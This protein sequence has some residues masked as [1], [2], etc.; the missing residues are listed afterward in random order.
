MFSRWGYNHYK[1][2][3]DVPGLHHRVKKAA[4]QFKKNKHEMTL[5]ITTKHKI[6]PT[7][8]TRFS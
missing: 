7:P 3:A 8:L 1:L 6:N 2:F 4:G 5:K